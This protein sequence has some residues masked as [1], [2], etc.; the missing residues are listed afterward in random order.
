M[1]LRPGT[2]KP[3]VADPRG[4]A[5]RSW[6]ASLIRRRGQVLGNVETPSREAAEAAAV[7][8]IAAL[9]ASSDLGF[10]AVEYLHDP[11]G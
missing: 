2:R 5:S 11:K 9:L 1:S 6:R 3:P 10:V 4:A 7:Q 8:D